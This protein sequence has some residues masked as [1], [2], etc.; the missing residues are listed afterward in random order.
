MSRPRIILADDHT[1]LAEGL[2]GILEPEFELLRT[3]AD[4][5]EL[6]AA[7]KELDPDVVVVDISMPNLNGIDA[8]EEL[9]R[10]GSRSKVVFLTMHQDVT[11]AKRAL[12]AG[13]AGFVLKHSAASELVAAIRA[14]LRGEVYVTPSIRE[15]L[16]VA[17]DANSD[18]VAASTGI[19]TLRQREIVQL[20]AEG[21]TAKEVATVLHL[22]TRTVENHKSRILATLNI[23]TTAEL[24]QYAIRH[25]II[26][27]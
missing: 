20:L 12:E 4:G 22:S 17:S 27:G 25:G 13:G 23:G 8:V 19:L 14:S 1:M 10:S 21:R 2:R 5:H 7:V 9:R 18:G 16:S 24:V 3:V 26:A 11:Y 6:I 15:G